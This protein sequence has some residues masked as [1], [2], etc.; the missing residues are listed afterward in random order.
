MLYSSVSVPNHVDMDPDS[1]SHIVKNGSGFDL[2]LR[3]ILFV[4]LKKVKLK[5]ILDF[6]PCN[7]F[8]KDV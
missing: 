8:I 7:W 6:K 4:S 2:K 1:W 3:N 5:K